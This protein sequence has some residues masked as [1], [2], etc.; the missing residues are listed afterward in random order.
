MQNPTSAITRDLKTPLRQLH[1][2]PN[3]HFSNPRAQHQSFWVL[4][5]CC[6]CFFNA[7]LP[8]KQ[9]GE[10]RI[11]LK[12]EWNVKPLCRHDRFNAKSNCIHDLASHTAL[13]TQLSGKKCCGSSTNHRYNTVLPPL[14]SFFPT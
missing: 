13:T 7:C 5:R 1:A 6:P 10:P 8:S 12:E 11:F 2:P 9:N 14:S 3:T 4:L